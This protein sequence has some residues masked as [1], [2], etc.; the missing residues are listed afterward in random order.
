MTIDEDRVIAAEVPEGARFKGYEDYVVQD[1]MLRRHVV[2]Y[3]RQRWLTGDGRMV[4]APLPA[5]ISGH[6]GPEL[7]RFV[8]AQYHRGQVTI[9][10]LVGLLRDIGVEISERQVVRLLNGRQEGFTAEAR[11]VLR[12]GLETARWITVDDTGARHKA[13]NGVCTQIGDHRFAWFGTTFSKSRLNFLSLLRAGHGDYVVNAAALDYMGKRS[14]SRAVIAVL[15]AHGSKRFAD[16]DAFD[17]LGIAALEV[18]PDAPSGGGAVGQRDVARLVEGRGDSATTPAS[19]TS[20]ITALCWVHAERL[21]HK[22]VGFN[23]SQRRAIERTRARVWRFYAAL[24]TYCRDPT[25]R[26][27]AA[28]DER[29]ERLFSTATGFATLDRLLARLHANKDALLVALERPDI[30][31]HTNRSENDIRCQVTKRKISG[32]TRSD[33]GR[34]ARD[35]FLGLMKTCD[36]L[37]VSFWDYLGSRLMV[38]DAPIIPALPNVIRQRASPA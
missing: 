22:L 35:A 6:F 26:R 12:A 19:S 31:L 34:D 2:R 23:E 32:G 13:A 4:V 14:L 16:E 27:K 36:K 20:A 25:P 1:L 5:G 9:P 17:R 21:I 30:P 29:F 7:R 3:R 15:A 10:R 11:E 24:K 18:R 8:L 37:G 33:A 38:A 28:L